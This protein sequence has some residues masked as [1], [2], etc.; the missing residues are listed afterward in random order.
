[1]DP[2]S[3]AFIKLYNSQCTQSLITYTG[4][5]YVSFI[6]EE[7]PGENLEEDQAER[8]EADELERQEAGELPSESAQ[9]DEPDVEEVA[10]A[11]NRTRSGHRVVLPS[12]FVNVTKV[13]EWKTEAADVAIKAELRMLFEELKALALRD[14]LGLCR[15][16]DISN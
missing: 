14:M 11:V 6:E 8:Q 12:R 7:I 5:D 4:F 15:G 16:I 1:M 13:K 3:S 10:D 2:F 9:E